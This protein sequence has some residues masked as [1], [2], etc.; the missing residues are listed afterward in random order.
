MMECKTIDVISVLCGKIM[1]EP[2][3]VCELLNFMT[4]DDLYTSMLPV[5]MEVCGPFLADQHPELA[6]ACH[7]E[8]APL[9]KRTIRDLLRKFGESSNVNPLPDGLW[10]SKDPVG[11]VKKAL[12]SGKMWAK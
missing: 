7:Q 6:D 8:A 11:E 9:S 12:K 2:G 3:G 1:G 10:F 5:A 4:G